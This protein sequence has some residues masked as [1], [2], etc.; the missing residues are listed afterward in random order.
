MVLHLVRH[1]EAGDK[2]AWTGPDRQRPLT[3]AGWRQAQ[4][5]ATELAGHPITTI[6]SSPALR[7]VQ[8]VEPIARRRGLEIQTDARLHVDADAGRATWLLLEAAQPHTMWCT[9][10]ELIGEVLGRLREAG[11]PIGDAPEWVKGSIWHLDVI[12][13]E[14]LRATYRPPGA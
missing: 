7:C 5:L 12:N 13:G 4:W 8:T 3:D 9:H 6:V 1:A 10:G 2:R 14:V 11:A